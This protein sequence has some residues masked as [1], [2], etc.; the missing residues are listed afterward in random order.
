MRHVS[1]PSRVGR[2][3]REEMEFAGESKETT[4]FD[5]EAAA[6]KEA[7]DGKKKSGLLLVFVGGA[8]ISCCVNYRAVLSTTSF[9]IIRAIMV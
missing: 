1:V 4:Y 9:V 8:G 3:A 5:E 7:V 2:Q 6:A